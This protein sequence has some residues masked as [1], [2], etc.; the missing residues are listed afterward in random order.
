MKKAWGALLLICTIHASVSGQS[1]SVEGWIG[2][3]PSPDGYISIIAQAKNLVNE[4]GEYNYSMEVTTTDA[5]GN[6]SNNSQF[7]TFSLLPGQTDTLSTVKINRSSEQ[8]IAVDLRILIGHIEIAR[9]F[10]ENAGATPETPP[11]KKSARAFKQEIP[12]DSSSLA[13]PNAIKEE[14][15]LLTDD[16]RPYDKAKY[17]TPTVKKSIRDSIAVAFPS[18]SVTRVVIKEKAVGGE[19][20]EVQQAQYGGDSIA[21]AIP[22]AEEEKVKLEKDAAAIEGLEIDG[23]IIDE[24]RTKAGRDFYSLFYSKWQAPVQASN[25]SIVLKEYPTRGR[26]SRLG[27]EVNG[28]LAYQSVLQPRSDLLELSAN[29]AISVVKQHLK[30]QKQ[31]KNQLDSDV[32]SG[33][34]IF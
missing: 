3:T 30:D 24:T 10:I 5:R 4:Q 15:T 13:F 21:I 28:K 16:D 2:L 14:T 7:G 11:I 31:L 29:Q 8:K 33:S 19:S 27:I 6:S 25:F 34:G 1:A 22:V 12:S 20:P 32:S 26:V 9:D 17:S 18:D 23:L